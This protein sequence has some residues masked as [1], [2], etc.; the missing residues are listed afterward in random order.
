MSS[1][2]FILRDEDK[3]TSALLQTHPISEVALL[4]IF[5]EQRVI[6]VY[7]LISNRNPI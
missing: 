3:Y 4:F 2:Y 5:A 7:C 6:E 1:A